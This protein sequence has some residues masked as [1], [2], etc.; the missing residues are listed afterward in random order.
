MADIEHIYL[1]D[2]QSGAALHE[3]GCSS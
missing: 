3:S 1:F 2:P